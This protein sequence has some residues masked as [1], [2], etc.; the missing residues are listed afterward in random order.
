MFVA[1]LFWLCKLA[2][3]V[4]HVSLLVCFV[5]LLCFALFIFIGFWCVSLP[6]SV[7]KNTPPEKNTCG[8]ISF[9]STKS[10]GG[11]EFLLLDRRAKARAKGVIIS[12]APVCTARR[13]SCTGFTIISTTYVSEIGKSN[14]TS[15]A[16]SEFHLKHV[17]FS[18]FK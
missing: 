3:V 2:C 10:G 15:A 1:D 6:V 8:E 7:N 17:L 16:W 5:D 4:L 14:T 13:D 18:L 11:K 12:Q 9:Q